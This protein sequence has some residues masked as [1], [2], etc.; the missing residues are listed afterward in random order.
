M[1]LA[2]AQVPAEGCEVRFTA[3]EAVLSDAGEGIRPRGGIAVE[4]RAEHEGSG[5]RV[6]GTV[7]AHL[8]L[9][10]A[11]CLGT[12]DFPVESRFDVT[13]SRVVPVEDEVELEGRELTVCH[14]EG[15]TVDL[16][17]LAR[18]E[19]LLAVPMAPLCAPDCRGLC[20]RCGA[21]LNQGPCGCEAA[22]AD[23]RFQVLGRLLEGAPSPSGGGRGEPRH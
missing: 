18:E 19:V 15:D 12:F 8:E 9:A 21:N 4:G 5:L 22:A 3:E 13:Y 2:L 7:R 20:P 14:L 11:R 1:K 17:E 10:C 23:P 6:T 16:S